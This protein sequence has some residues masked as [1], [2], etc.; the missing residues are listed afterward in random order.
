MALD[1]FGRFIK[2]L[3][4]DST[5]SGQKDAV[6]DLYRTG[7]NLSSGGFNEERP[8]NIHLIFCAE[9]ATGARRGRGISQAVEVSLHWIEKESRRMP[10]LLEDS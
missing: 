9:N 6:P 8:F 7:T 4:P 1:L 2:P 10:I 3:T 5:C